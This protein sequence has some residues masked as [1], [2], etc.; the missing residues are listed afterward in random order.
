MLYIV[1][2]FRLSPSLHGGGVVIFCLVHYF[3]SF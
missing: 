1:V 3:S 2:I